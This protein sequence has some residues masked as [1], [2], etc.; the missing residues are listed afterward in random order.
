[1]L[2]EDAAF[3]NEGIGE[4]ELCL[5]IECSPCPFRVRCRAVAV[6]LSIY[7]K[8][9]TTQRQH[10]LSH[11][12]FVLIRCSRRVELWRRKASSTTSP[13]YAIDNDTQICVDDQMSAHPQTAYCISHE[14]FVQVALTSSDFSSHTLPPVPVGSSEQL[15]LRVTN[16]G[17]KLWEKQYYI[18]LDTERCN[19][20]NSLDCH[21]L[22][23]EHCEDYYGRTLAPVDSNANVYLTTVAIKEPGVHFWLSRLVFQ[24]VLIGLKCSC[25]AKKARGKQSHVTRNTAGARLK[26]QE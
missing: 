12:S 20:R 5:F 15:Q 25:A 8:P 21:F 16:P 7:H 9:D 1:M 10:P 26:G 14:N 23:S 4:A 13:S 24:L 22:Q 17:N 3:S 6:L 19:K 11:H 2:E 18:Q